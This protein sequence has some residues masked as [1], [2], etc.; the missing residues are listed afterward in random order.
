[1]KKR[2]MI[3]PAIS[4]AALIIY[5]LCISAKTLPPEKYSSEW[6]EGLS[7]LDWEREREIVRQKYCNAEDGAA[8]SYLQR[9]LWLFDKIRYEKNNSDKEYR[10]PAYHREHGYNLYKPEE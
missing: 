2:I 7:D 5:K 4:T 10:G 9:L 3:L 1:M 8:A 6:I